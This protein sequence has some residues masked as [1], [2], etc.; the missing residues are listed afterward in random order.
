M[1]FAVLAFLK[2]DGMAL[3]GGNA[4]QYNADLRS[5]RSCASDQHWTMVMFFL[6]RLS[7]IRLSR[8]LGPD[9][10]PFH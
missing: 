9:I 2:A 1:I 5:H 4:R 3:N 6:P 8:F 10:D 7:L